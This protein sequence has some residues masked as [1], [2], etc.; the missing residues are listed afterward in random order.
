[1]SLIEF[2]PQIKLIH[3]SLALSSG[4]LFTLRGFAVLINARWPMQRQVR[5][6]SVVIDTGLLLA[7]LALLTALHLNPLVIS[8][9]QAKLGLLLA[10]IAFGILALHRAP[11]RARKLAAYCAALSCFGMMI[12]VARTHNPVGILTLL[13][14]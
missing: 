13:R 5:N 12:V 1:M 7:A 10:Y 14:F 11:T 6:L 3:I 4:A 9:L 8:W 2:Y